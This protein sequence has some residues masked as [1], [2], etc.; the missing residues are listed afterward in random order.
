MSSPHS[1]SLADV[2]RGQHNASLE[3]L[4]PP[5]VSQQL[6]ILTRH[7]PTKI[8]SL[9]GYELPVDKPEVSSDFLL[10]L[11]EANVCN[12]VMQTD[13]GLRDVITEPL[14]DR[15]RE[16]ITRWADPADRVGQVISNFWL[17]YDYDGVLPGQVSPNL[18]FGPK[19]NCR[20]LEVVSASRQIFEQL[21]PQEMPKG[22]Y[23][24]L[25][26]CMSLLGPAGGI[27]QIGQM[28]ARRENRLRLFI[29]HLPVQGILPYLRRLDYPHAD[30]PLLIAQLD[31]CYQL[32]DRVDVDIDITDRIGS[33]L[34]LECYFNTTEKAIWFLDDLTG[35]GLCVP[36]KY[37][38]LREHL[39]N[40][41]PTTDDPLVP[42]F[43]HVK[44]GFHP[45]KGFSSKVYIG[46]ARR[47]IA[48]AVIHTQPVKIP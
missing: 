45:D 3:R 43:S 13:A 16:L 38:L 22:T 12:E 27:T 46:Y 32:A 2:I 24:F 44:V 30:N 23:P 31:R 41:Q 26:R 48:S 8:T 35:R 33:Q 25:V 14:H 9:W 36:Q 40:I 19:G 17:E 7:L 4:I 21:S 34:G 18:F 5:A 28:L 20:L 29:Q 37:Q 11:H 1:D 47:S 15:L 10:C 42:F 39:L 6:A